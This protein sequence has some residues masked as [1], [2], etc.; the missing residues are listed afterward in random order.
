MIKSI[1]DFVEDYL[2]DEENKHKQ[3]AWALRTYVYLNFPP[4]NKEKLDIY[5]AMFSDIAINNEDGDEEKI[6]Y[7]LKN[8]I[9]L[10]RAI[11]Q[12]KLED[13]ELNEIELNKSIYN[14]R[15]L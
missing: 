8:I 4:S 1:Q 3:I 10:G 7:A 13:N 2:P 14:L 6:R 5:E 15:D 12:P 11:N 9:R